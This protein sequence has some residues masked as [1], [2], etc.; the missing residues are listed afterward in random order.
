MKKTVITLTIT[1]IFFTVFS[2]IAIAN[3]VPVVTDVL[4]SELNGANTGITV[5]NLVMTFSG[6]RKICDVGPVVHQYDWRV[7]LTKGGKKFILEVTST[8]KKG[9]PNSFHYMMAELA[10]FIKKNA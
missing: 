8:S 1:A 6:D 3:E 4:Q 2:S 7:E 9:C 5:N 10:I